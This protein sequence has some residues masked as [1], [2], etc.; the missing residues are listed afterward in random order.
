MSEHVVIVGA[1]PGGYVAAIRAAQLG[2]E[3]TVVENDEVGGTC[4]NRGCIPTKALVY[5]AEA[6]E[7]VR[8]ARDYGVEVA[9]EVTYSLEAM[10][11]RKDKVVSTQVKGI[12][13]LFKSH[14]IRLIEGTGSLR[15]ARTVTVQLREG[16]T[17]DVAAD[18]II[19]A[20]GSRPAN[21]PVFPLDGEKIISSD[22]ALFL[23]KLPG[24]L[25]VIGAGVIG[26][27]FAF[28]LNALG[29]KITMVEMMPHAIPLVDEEITALL[30][31]E[32]KKKKIKLYC[33]EK[34]ESVKENGEG[35]M[36]A[37]LASGKEII[38]DQVL[39][40][41]GR[42]FN[43]DGLNLDA[44]GV[45]VG[46][47]GNIE[48]NEKLETSVPG[49]YAIGDV[50]GGILL[51]HVA[52]TEGIAAAENALGKESPVDYS[53]VPGAIFTMPEIGTVGLTEA[54]AREKGFDVAVGTFPY[55]GLGKSHAMGKITGMAKIV[56]DA[57]TDRLLGMHILGAHASDIVQE[58]ALVMKLGGTVR[59]LG[60]TIHSHPTL[61]EVVME[62]AHAV[63]GICIHLPKPKE[64]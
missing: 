21:I 45:K 25:L 54:Q 59:D 23:K 63:H 31:R 33:D 17:E 46:P 38:T 36:V 16:G 51:A 49:I 27:E 47:R 26:C 44:A 18:R 62:T 24:T 7:M 60:D 2:A 8:H 32:L 22:D 28:I 12:R 14:K 43:T 3:V 20:T 6:L 4:L 19:L 35:K 56:A 52:S 30:E 37:S 55:R 58:G 64:R 9:G 50:T 42:T 5:S 10:M 29:V 40:S 15:D 39:V 34:I 41:I 1:G 61:S 53:V 13:S 48:V 57:K 11:K